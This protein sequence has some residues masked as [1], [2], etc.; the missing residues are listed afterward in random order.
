MG[1]T[2]E[3]QTPDGAAEAYLTG[4]PGRPGVLFYIDAI[5]LR[6]RTREMAD[7][8]ASWGYVV[9][10]PNVFHRD[11][12]AADLAPS[13]DLREPGARERFFQGAMRRVRGLTPDLSNPDARLWV[14]AL[15]EHASGPVGVT[16]YC[17][18]ARLA[19]RTAGLL[20]E[21]VAAVGGFH[22]GGLATDDPQ[23]PHRTLG[24]ARAEF[25]FGH[26]DHDRSMGPEAIAE[27]GRAL[28]A[29]GLTAKNEVYAGAAHGY[30]MADTSAYDEAATERHFTELEALLGRT[31]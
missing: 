30:T 17:M 25:V 23:S 3:I 14:D 19:V 10:A 11:G 5:G 26:A 12:R 18:G 4:E 24:D 9:L 15:L 31:L 8:I 20:A 29:A 7:R 27:L 22:G 2:I 16:G 13:E 1:T 21:Q 28:D 6:P